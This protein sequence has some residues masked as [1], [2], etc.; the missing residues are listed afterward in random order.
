[1]SNNKNMK[2]RKVEKQNLSGLEHLNFSNFRKTTRY[3]LCIW[4]SFIVVLMAACTPAVSLRQDAT[5]KPDDTAAPTALPTFTPAPEPAQGM[6]YVDPGQNLGPINPLVYGSNY[7][8]WLFV[9][10]EM[11]PQ[12]VAA[13]ITY[14]RFP[15]GNWGDLNDLDEWQIDQYIAL[16]KELGSEPA[17]SVRL[18]DG[19]P[20]KAAALVQLVNQTKQYNVRYWSIGN[21]PSLFPGY[22]T[23]RYNQE[24]RQFA[25]AMR[26]VDPTI[27][28]VGPDTHQITT[29]PARNPKDSAGKDW[30]EE[31]LK[32]NGDLVDIVSVHRYPFPQDRSDPSPK[33]AGLRQNSRE[34]DAIIPF[35]Q[36]L[37]RQHTGR[38]LPLA[39]TEVNSSWAANSGGEGTM[40]SHYNAIWWADALARMIRQGVDIVA[41]FALV[42]E[43]GL[44]GKYEVY[45]IYYVY[46]MYQQMGKELLYASSD[47][48][49]LTVLASRRSDS[50]VALMVINLSTEN[51]AYPLQIQSLEAAV[52][53]VVWR[54][55][56]S[57]NAE[58][59]TSQAIGPDT[60][61][62]LP[63][64]SIN[65]YIFSLP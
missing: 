37:V 59:D 61:L 54:F 38:D 44:M 34:W 2:T 3:T 10:L 30:L 62:S 42:G 14:L 23:A 64:Q 25:Q 57:H 41:Q 20:E 7:G 24:W 35:L 26:A 46:P 5:P 49:D 19:T 33:I 48:P 12:A 1:M 43:F 11:R 9:T 60:T 18:R 16:C 50:K 13:G 56:L 28:F 21:E 65:V 58:Q 39:I 32:A 47:N 29:D 27:V 53:A 40:D 4:L 6:L 55:D 17:I 52:E 8:P 63:P 36:T 45:P 22:D 15:G 31:F 51:V